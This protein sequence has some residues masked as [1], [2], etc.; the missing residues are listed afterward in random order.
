MSWDIFAF[1]TTQ[2]VTSVEEIDESFFIPISFDQVFLN[3]FPNVT[4][5][6]D[7][8]TV[9]GEGFSFDYYASSDL[10]GTAMLQVSGEKALFEI[11]D[12]A[13]KNGWLLYDTG[14]GEMIDLEFPERNGY[15]NFKSYREQIL[16]NSKQQDDSSRS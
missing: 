6:A 1:S 9:E 3:W 8:R 5:T 15:E 12:V 11:V 2:K 16:S 4:S 13:M 14:N 7:H 10:E